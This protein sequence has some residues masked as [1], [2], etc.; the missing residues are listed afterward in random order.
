[1]GKLFHRCW[2][3]FIGGSFLLILGCSPMPN[4]EIQL[5]CAPH[6]HVLTNTAVWSPDGQWIVYDTRPDPAG[7]T[8]ASDTIERVNVRTREVQRLYTA[9]NGAHC[10]V[11]TYHPR[12]DKVVFILGPEHPTPDWTYGPD[13][14]QGVI[15][16]ADRPGVATNLDAR[17]LVGPFTPGALRGGSHVHVFSPDGSKVAFT[18][19]DHVCHPGERNVA[20]AFPRPVT[21]PR[22]HPRNQDGQWFTVLISRT[23]ANPTPGSDEVRRAFEDTWVG[24][25]R[26]VF[27]GEVIAGNGKP[28]IELFTVRLPAD[29]TIAG[30]DGPLQGTATTLPAPP[31]GVVQQR[32][33]RTTERKYPGL[34]TEPR[35]WPR[36]SPDGKRVAFL[37]KDDQGVTQLWTIPPEGGRPSPLTYNP[38]GVTSAFTWSPDGRSIAHTMDHS[39]SI[40]DATTGRTMR[41]T[42][43]TPGPDSPR[44]EAVV[45]SP[46][47]RQV[48]FVRNVS[49]HNQVFIVPAVGR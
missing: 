38:T 27:C 48:A 24:Q 6:G 28:V 39:V 26:I 41:L 47:G 31:K 25:E 45:F 29:L 30:E 37:M 7:S 10:G 2:S 34:V 20:V 36:P 19:N 8:F 13:R 40:T 44:P 14:R 4:R 18:Y 15:V 42:A 17:D 49:G 23:M 5:T 22:T 33:T 1:M 43:P 35:H 16:E 12:E 46:D 11:V 3:V 9:Q 32:V 21:V